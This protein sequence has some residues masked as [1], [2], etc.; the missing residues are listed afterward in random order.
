M[1]RGRKP[2]PGREKRG[3]GHRPLPGKAKPVEILPAYGFD[4][5]P[6]ESIP[7]EAQEIWRRACAELEGKGLRE[8][9]LPLIE[10]LVVAAYRNRQARALVAKLDLLVKG[11]KGPVVNPLLK[12]EKDTAATYLRLA[13]TLGLS[14]AG[15]A[16]LGFL[17]IAGQSL[18]VDIAERVARAAAAQK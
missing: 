7:A 4:L 10:M 6:P 1:T 15:R 13:E 5:S 18:L 16:R 11:D 8:A 2:D 14:P 3:T 12:V 17:H 9:D